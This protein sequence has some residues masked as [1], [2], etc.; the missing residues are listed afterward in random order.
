MASAP[1]WGTQRVNGHHANDPSHWSQDRERRP[2]PAC[3]APMV[4]GSRGWYHADMRDW[5]PACFR[6]E[7][8]PR[9][10]PAYAQAPLFEVA[11]G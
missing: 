9:N 4:Q 10:A 2:C 7:R 11:R 6:P 3:E 5:T 1:T 8:T